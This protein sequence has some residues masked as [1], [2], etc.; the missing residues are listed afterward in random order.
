VLGE[1]EADAARAAS[2]ENR[3]LRHRASV[4]NGAANANEAFGQMTQDPNEGGMEAAS[5]LDLEMS[6]GQTLF[7][8]FAQQSKIGQL[9]TSLPPNQEMTKCEQF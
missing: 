7:R 8:D 5:T 6:Q 9:R 3:L 2:D 1:L 4:G